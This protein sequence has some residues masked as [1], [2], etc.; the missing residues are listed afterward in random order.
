MEEVHVVCGAPAVCLTEQGVAV[1][2]TRGCY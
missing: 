1:E 2:K